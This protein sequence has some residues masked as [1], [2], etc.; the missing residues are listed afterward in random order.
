MTA[1]PKVVTNAAAAP[2]RDVVRHGQ[3]LLLATVIALELILGGAML[4]HGVRQPV[5]SN[6]DEAFH[7]DYVVRM[8]HGSM[9]VVGNTYV[10]PR[11]LALAQHRY[12]GPP[13]VPPKQAGW[14]GNSYEAVQPPLYYFIAAPVSMLWRTLNKTGFSN[15]LGL[16]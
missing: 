6:G 13:A 1:S 9:P 5:F 14:A 8:A 10:D 16:A 7:L 4:V 2:R 3:R 12:P 11:V 15:I